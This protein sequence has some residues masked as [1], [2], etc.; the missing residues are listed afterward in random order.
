MIVDGKKWCP[1]CKT[2]RL[3]SEFSVN[4]SKRSSSDGYSSKCKACFAAYCRERR[5]TIPSERDRSRRWAKNHPE[6]TAEYSR[7][8]RLAN[9]D[10]TA[11]AQRAWREK[12]DMSAYRKDWRAR[13]LDAVRKKDAAWKR[14]FR[15][16]NTEYVRLKDQE[17][18]LVRRFNAAGTLSYDE[19]TSIVAEFDHRC[20]YC[21]MHG[22][23]LVME[24]MLP[25]ARG[26][27]FGKSVEEL[28][29]ASN[30]VPACR[31]CNCKKWKFTPLEFAKRHGKS[32]NEFLLY[33][34][35]PLP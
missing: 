26:K 5:L 13:S 23:N 15:R 7:R 6:K 18:S 12:T 8:Y 1:R 19:W 21:G 31:S 34:L 17:R 25:L 30:V 9:P 27:E 29:T 28:H 11:A 22:S 32:P 3:V 4:K 10:K 14:Q 35:R 33:Q 20:A 24:H 16:N 2:M